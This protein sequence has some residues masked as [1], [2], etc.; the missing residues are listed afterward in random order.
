[1]KRIALLFIIASACLLSCKDASQSREIVFD[2]PIVET[3]RNTGNYG[4]YNGVITEE[5][6]RNYLSRAITEA[7]FL[8]SER[9]N[10]DGYYGTE[11]DERMLLNIGAKFVGRAMYSWGKE[12]TFLDT[13]RFTDAKARI[14][15]MHAKDPDIIFQACL[16]EIITPQ[17]ENIKIPDWVFE[18]FG[19][20]PEDRNFSY[21][22]IK[23]D[24]EANQNQWGENTGVPDISKEEAQMWF[25]YMA[26]RYMEIGIEALHCGQ[27]MLMSSFGDSAQGYPSYTKLFKL[28]REAA[29]TK[30]RR[31]IVL[32][33]SHCTGMKLGDGNILLDSGAFPM[34]LKEIETST[35]F[36]AE[37]KPGY[38]D[39]MIGLTVSGTTPS[40]WKTD[41]LPYMLEF[42]NWGISDHPGKY[43]KSGDIYCWGYDEISWFS[44]LDE[45]TAEE[46]LRYAVTWMADNDP[47]GYI[48]MPGCRI[49]YGGKGWPEVRAY[50]CN[51]KSDACPTGRNMENVIKAIWSQK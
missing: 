37:L 20:A 43:K 22:A 10:I 19:K 26:V 1:M 16:F 21:N 35:K 33:D 17:V 3:W 14:D 11:D 45:E 6:L 39:S 4:I 34:R 44:Q 46:F 42:D 38:L 18:A 31:G 36:E 50:R 12:T 13:Q 40:G 2:Y 15:R 51:T 9:L 29:K 32:L 7:E 49:A 47:M 24:K 30:A 23:T 8:H 5:V 27:T 41:R 25:Y 28:I 48:E